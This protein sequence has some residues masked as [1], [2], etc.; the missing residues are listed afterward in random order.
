MNLRS[1]KRIAVSTLLACTAFTA[2]AMALDLTVSWQPNPEP[3][4]AGYQVSYGSESGNY[5]QSVDAGNGTSCLLTNI[6]EGVPYFIAVRAYDTAR[7]FSAYSGEA[8]FFQ[9]APPAPP[10]DPPFE[11]G[12][13]DLFYW[14]AD[15]DVVEYSAGGDGAITPVG[16]ITYAPGLDGNALSISSV[17]SWAEFFAFG[18]VD[19][20]QGAIE[21]HLNPSWSNRDTRTR[22][23]FQIG[24]GKKNC[25]KCWFYR[26]GLYLYAWD[27]AGVMRRTYLLSSKYSLPAGDWT[28]IKAVW[29][30]HAT[31]TDNLAIY[32]NDVKKAWLSK[33][34]WSTKRMDF[35]NASV[36]LGQSPEASNWTLNGL[37]D[38]VR[39]TK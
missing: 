28:T 2:P 9:P 12:P 38:E 14:K 6:Q 11:P 3:D 15:S 22:L 26:G 39:I 37:I 36:Y 7:Q 4:I 23:L 19:P 33:K 25:I 30:D 31:D 8:T 5:T 17:R 10:S 13:G 32:I 18:N 34:P 27:G 20:A 24:S 16:S 35:S 29:N 21:L 1:L